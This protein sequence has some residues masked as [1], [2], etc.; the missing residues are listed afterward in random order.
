MKN[1]NIKVDAKITITSPDGTRQVMVIENYRAERC[2]LTRP[3]VQLPAV[4]GDL[5]AH[6]VP[7][8]LTYIT[9]VLV[10]QEQPKWE[11]QP[12]KPFWHQGPTETDPDPA[13]M[14]HSGDCGGEVYYL[15]GAHIC[16][17][18]NSEEEEK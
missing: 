14:W 3:P 6:Y 4:E 1:L 7:G 9:M 13:K 8:P 15:G 5:F 18:C 2:E 12:P 10:T 16:S 17:A 11:Q